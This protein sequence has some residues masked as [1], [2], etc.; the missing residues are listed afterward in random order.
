MLQSQATVLSASF[1]SVPNNKLLFTNIFLD[2]D[3]ASECNSS[4]VAYSSRSLS[5]PASLPLPLPPPLPPSPCHRPLSDLEIEKA[6]LGAGPFRSGQ[7]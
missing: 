2:D 1:H 6:L 4:P 5:L 7:E 3:D